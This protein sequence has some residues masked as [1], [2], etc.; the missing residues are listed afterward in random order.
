MIHGQ[1]NVKVTFLA[2]IHASRF[3][4]K[5]SSLIFRQFVNTVKPA[6]NGTAKTY[7]FPF[8]SG[9]VLHMYLESKSC[10]L[11]VVMTVKVFRQR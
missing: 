5:C 7:F 11:Q 4:N 8:K 6:Y 10:S 2:F 3:Q 9:S 1:T